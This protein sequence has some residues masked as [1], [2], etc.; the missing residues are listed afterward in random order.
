MVDSL[1]DFAAL[2]DVEGE[3]LIEFSEYAYTGEHVTPK[4]SMGQPLD[5]TLVLDLGNST[6]RLNGLSMGKS[7]DP[8]M[9]MLMVLMV[10]TQRSRM[11]VLRKE[12]R[13]SFLRLR[14]RSHSS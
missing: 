7:E 4:L 5:S 6:N 3:T 9:M 14:I 1:A 2:D 10:L 12:A 11:R 8:G 13:P